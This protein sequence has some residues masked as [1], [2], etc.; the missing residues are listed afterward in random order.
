VSEDPAT[1]EIQ[2]LAVRAA[3]QQNGLHRFRARRW[4]MNDNQGVAMTTPPEDDVDTSA[5]TE[6]RPAANWP[7]SLRIT[8]PNI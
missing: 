2:D 6:V 3:R 4:I 8:R 7:L 1:E 5:A